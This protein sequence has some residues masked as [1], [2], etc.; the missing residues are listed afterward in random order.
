[1]FGLN[2]QL[3]IYAFSCVANLLGSSPGKH[4]TSDAECSGTSTS[5]IL[6]MNKQLK[7]L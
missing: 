3:H 2:N 5:V 7:D 4:S 1:M 6:V